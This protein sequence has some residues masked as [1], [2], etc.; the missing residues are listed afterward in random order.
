MHGRGSKPLRY[1]TDVVGSPAVG[2]GEALTFDI[3]QVGSVY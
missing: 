2:G 3:A 1:A